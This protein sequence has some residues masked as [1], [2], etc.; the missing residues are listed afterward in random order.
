MSAVLPISESVDIEEASRGTP[1]AARRAR[2]AA[3]LDKAFEHLT[4]FFALL[5]FSLLAAILVSLV[6]GSREIGRAHV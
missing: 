4:R 3:W 6:L 2:H 1:P 5:V